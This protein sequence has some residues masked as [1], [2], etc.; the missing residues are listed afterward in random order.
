MKRSLKS[1]CSA[2]GTREFNECKK[3]RFEVTQR[4]NDVHGP[5]NKTKEYLN[6]CDSDQLIKVIIILC[7]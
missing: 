6:M 7:H 3:V 4:V 2:R 5:L 1:L